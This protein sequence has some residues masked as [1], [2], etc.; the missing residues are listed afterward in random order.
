[1]VAE[2]ARTGVWDEVQLGFGVLLAVLVIVR[3]R[4]NIGRLL[5]GTEPRAG[6]KKPVA[7]NEGGEGA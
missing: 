6:K 7:A 5:A 1:M 3:H 4:A 2:M